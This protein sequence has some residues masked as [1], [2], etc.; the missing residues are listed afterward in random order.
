MNA[1]GYSLGAMF[2]PMWMDHPMFYTGNPF[3]LDENMIFFVHI[4]LMNSDS[5]RAM[6]LGQT[7]RVSAN[8]MERLSRQPTD[9]VRV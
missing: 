9:L 6:T 3:V 5:G 1:C 8:G 7:V 4:I 2:T